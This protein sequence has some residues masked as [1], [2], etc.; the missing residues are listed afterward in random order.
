M[1]TNVI[2]KYLFFIMGASCVASAQSQV[3][4]GGGGH[5]M[6]PLGDYGGSA[7]DFYLGSKYGAGVG[8]GFQLKSRFEFA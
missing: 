8:L 1:K 7:N 6:L 2:T 4:F 5:I 3:Q